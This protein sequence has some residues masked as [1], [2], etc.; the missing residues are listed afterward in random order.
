M[1]AEELF[2]QKKWLFF[3]GIKALILNKGKILLLSSGIPELSSTKRSRIFWDL[4]GGKA[5]WGESVAETL[6][7]EVEEELGIRKS[8]LKIIRIFEASISRIRT[9]H[10]IRVPLLLVTFLCSLRTNKRKFRLSDEHASYKWV[11]IKDGKRL[12][13]AKFSR[14]FIE[15]LA[16]LGGTD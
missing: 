1:K 9:S 13:G 4:P 14:S 8:D 15:E 6:R 7:R 10:G 5:E 3:V 2:K 11:S 12:L 16:T